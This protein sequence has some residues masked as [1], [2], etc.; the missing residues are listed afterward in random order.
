MRISKQFVLVVALVLGSTWFPTASVSARQEPAAQKSGEQELSPTQQQAVDAI[1]AALAAADKTRELSQR[2]KLTTRAADVLWNVDPARARDLFRKAFSSIDGDTLAREA[3]SDARAAA[4]VEADE[5]AEPA[6]AQS[7]TARWASVAA[8]NLR[9]HVLKSLARRD[10]NLAEELLESVLE[11]KKDD[12]QG[13]PFSMFMGDSRS[14]MKLQFARQLLDIDIKRA[15]GMVSSVLATEVPPELTPLLIR[16]GRQDRAAADQLFLMAVQ[17]IKITQPPNLISA[18]QLFGYFAKQSALGT[19][20]F[21]VTNPAVAQAYIPVLADL[22]LGLEVPAGPVLPPDPSAPPSEEAIMGMFQ[23]MLG[24]FLGQLALQSPFVAF[25]SERQAALQ[26]KVMLLKARFP[27]EQSEQFETML[28]L[29]NDEDAAATLSAK[30]EKSTRPEERDHLYLSAAMIAIEKGEF[31]QAESLLAKVSNA[32]LRG[33][34]ASYL[35]FSR[36]R[37]LIK[38]K[39]LDQAARMAAKVEKL[40]DRIALLTQIAAAA[41][42]ANDAPRAVELLN[43]AEKLVAKVTEPRE[44]VSSLLGVAS[45]FASVDKLRSFEVLETAVKQINA[46]KEH[47][48]ESG[49]EMFAE[50][51]D[52]LQTEE[53]D[54]QQD[55]VRALSGVNQ[56]NFGAFNLTLTSLAKSD[57]Q[58][59]ML[60]ARSVDAPFQ[61]AQAELAVAEGVL[62]KR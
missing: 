17:R 6:D 32:D 48:S 44:K 3:I 33:Q 10:P 60:I 11:E 43:E 38:N 54:E 39:D 20:R 21:E 49:S 29:Q 22:V 14:R 46:A 9:M 56:F 1:D 42:S 58:R 31:S 47:L 37:R 18:A 5:E 24:Y 28:N 40:A 30:A 45:A 26:Q 23:P 34:I 2:I 12:K 25:V 35:N 52:M 50:T 57:F 61:R 16:L 59:A 53:E 15:E 41:A 7:E 51:M 8:A 55:L 13:L 27:A 19:A 62:T 4:H 36:I